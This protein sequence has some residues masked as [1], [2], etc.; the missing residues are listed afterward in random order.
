MQKNIGKNKILPKSNRI[1]QITTQLAPKILPK[2]LPKSY[3]IEIFIPFSTIFFCLPKGYFATKQKG[4]AAAKIENKNQYKW[5]V[6]RVEELLPLV[7]D[8]TLIGNADGVGLKYVASLI[9]SETATF[10]KDNRAAHRVALFVFC[11]KTLIL[12]P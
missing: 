11:N 4:L 12:N 10:D 5:A 7:T 8:D 6:K 1:S 9:M 3:M 2:F